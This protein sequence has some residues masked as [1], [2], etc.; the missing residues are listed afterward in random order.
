MT[1]PSAA[2]SQVVITPVGETACSVVFGNNIT[3][4]LN[5][6]V[7]A[8]DQALHT[9]EIAGIRE[10]VPGYSALL[11]TYDP[12]VIDFKDIQGTI[13]N[14]LKQIE[15]AP[16][17]E[18]RVIEIPVRYG[19]MWGPDLPDVAAHCGLSKD[20]VIRRHTGPLYQVAMLGFAPGFTYLMGLP[21]QLATPRLPTPRVRVAAGSVGIAGAQTGIY[22]LQTPG[23]WR[24]IGRTDMALFK[25]DRKA[26]FTVHAGDFVRFIKT[27]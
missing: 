10:T 2:N 4:D 8:L 1:H 7:H 25:A 3:P 21:Q 11:I 12:L 19:G 17:T 9:Q 27:R 14:L 23:G 22:A 16:P 5:Y 20:A 6:K 18:S 15:I 26:P 24:I 13:W